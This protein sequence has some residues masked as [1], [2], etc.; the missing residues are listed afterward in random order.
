MTME[1]D[2]AQDCAHSVG[3]A[4]FTK[5]KNLQCNALQ[6]GDSHWAKCEVGSMSLL[7]ININGECP[8]S[9]APGR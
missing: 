6:V 3:P 4:E 5:G 7:H 9:T 8:S 2:F 1:V